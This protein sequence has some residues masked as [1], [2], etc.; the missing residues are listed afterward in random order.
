MQLKVHKRKSRVLSHL[1][2]LFLTRFP[3]TSYNIKGQGFGN[4]M[5]ISELFTVAGY[6]HMAG[7]I[8]CR[9]IFCAKCTSSAQQ[10]KNVQID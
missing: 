7:F 6:F 9:E 3:H 10:K 1:S 5:H 4:K 2:Q 8:N